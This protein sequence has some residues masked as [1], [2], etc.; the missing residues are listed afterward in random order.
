MLNE[1]STDDMMMEVDAK[2]QR[3]HPRKTCWEA[4]KRI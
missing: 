2:K 4:V 1:C 3:E